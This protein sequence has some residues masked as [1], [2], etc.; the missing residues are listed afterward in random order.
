M[1]WQSQLKQNSLPW[2]LETDSP[3]VRYLALR[4]LLDRPAD[5]FELGEARRTAHTAGP[6][7]TILGKMNEEG[8]WEKPGP[9][10][11]PKYRSTVWSLIML[12]QLGATVS[13]DERIA[14]AC[15]YLLDH[16]LFPGGLL[17]A[18]RIPSVTI[19]CLQGNLC[20]ALV[21]MGCTDPRL[22]SAYD[23]MARSVTGE[24]VAPKE[25]KKAA[26]RYFADKM[27]TQFCLWC[28]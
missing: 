5:D 28:E 25:D 10:Y 4:D 22:E 8:Y 20:W 16:A 13:E 23:W 3:G 27:R 19:D 12:A 2:L 9:G 14:R 11:G 21:E 1:S 18:S 6:I 7:A 26:L 17:S 15:V 24:G